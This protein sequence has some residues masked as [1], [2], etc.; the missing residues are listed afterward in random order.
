MMSMR[1]RS[2][3]DLARELSDIR[4]IEAIFGSSTPNAFEEKR[5]CPRE[6]TRRGPLRGRANGPGLIEYAW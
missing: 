5:K 2:A 3:H 4:D 1:Y 6:A